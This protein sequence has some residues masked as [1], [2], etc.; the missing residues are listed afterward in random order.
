ME[1]FDPT[2]DQNLITR[3]LLVHPDRDRFNSLQLRE[4][5]A[6]SGLQ[7]QQTFEL[8]RFGILGIGV[9]II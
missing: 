3:H 1:E 6:D 9:K 7:L 8:K 4:A 5:F 2:L